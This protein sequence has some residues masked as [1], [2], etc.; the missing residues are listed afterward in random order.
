VGGIRWHSMKLSQITSNIPAG[1]SLTIANALFKFLNDK[2][3]IHC[4]LTTASVEPQVAATQCVAKTISSWQN[5]KHV[6]RTS[7]T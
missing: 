1:D 5:V 3:M 6:I 2:W 7:S 4:P